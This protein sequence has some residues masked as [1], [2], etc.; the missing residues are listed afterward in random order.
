MT[1]DGIA[2]P[3]FTE[4]AVK[5]ARGELGRTTSRSTLRPAQGERHDFKLTDYR[6]SAT[7]VIVGA[8]RK[9]APLFC[10]VDI[11]YKIQNHSL[12]AKTF[13]MKGSAEVAPT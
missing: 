6:P 10:I 13:P 11:S 7:L 12:M 9:L 4:Q 2:I 8:F 5:S 3:I 1:L